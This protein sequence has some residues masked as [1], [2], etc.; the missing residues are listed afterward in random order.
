LDYIEMAGSTDHKKASLKRAAGEQAPT[1]KG[2][3]HIC[4]VI[5]EEMNEAAVTLSLDGTILYANGRFSELVKTPLDHAIGASFA[6]FVAEAYQ[7]HLGALLAAEEKCREEI[8]MRTAGGTLVPV[9]ISCSRMDIDH[10]P[11][12]CVIATD[13]TER[14]RQERAIAEERRHAAETDRANDRLAT[15]ALAATALAHEIA[16]PLQWMLSTVQLM[17][18]DLA[19]GDTTA[20]ASWKQQLGEFRGEIGRLASMLQDFGT[21]ARPEN[22]A[23]AAVPL[24]ALMSELRKIILPQLVTA[25][26]AVDY[27]IPDDLP[28]IHGD[29]DK[30]KQVLANLCKNAIEAT[31]AGGTLTIK[32]SAESENVIIE[33]V[34]TG[35]GIPEGF[36][37]FKPFATT[38]ERGS[39]LGLTIVRQIVAAHGGSITYQSDKGKGTTFRITLPTVKNRHPLNP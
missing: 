13:L 23:L 22:L 29:A 5:V 14:M 36:D 37:I 30:M 15:V 27:E 28:F 21:L 31:S 34:D 3:D 4:R 7:N 20:M 17:Q 6:S 38:K 11:A 25:G 1:L 18:E 8:E 10:F 39:G 35:T 32:A 26:I 19:G 33:I 12:I 9:A 2:A 16:N 24:P